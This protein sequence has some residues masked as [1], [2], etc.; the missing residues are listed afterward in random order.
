M[1]SSTLLKIRIWTKVTLLALLLIYLAAFVFRNRGE[2]LSLWLFPTVSFENVNTLLALLIV[3]L[4]GALFALLIRT[5]FS[6]VRQ[7]RESR[8]RSRAQKLEREIVDMRTKS[9]KL[10]ARQ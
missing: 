9:S 8:Q 10:Q 5:I 1:A 7:I 2:T 3:F 6:T 4:L